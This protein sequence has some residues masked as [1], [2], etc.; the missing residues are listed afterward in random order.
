MSCDRPAASVRILPTAAGLLLLNTSSNCLW[1]CNDSARQVWQLIEQGRSGDDLAV[2]FA[3]QHGIPADAARRDVDAIVTQ[4][5]SE[6]FISTNGR[7]RKPIGGRSESGD[8][9]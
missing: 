7:S 9:I 2:D 6:G 8:R 1:A 3:R 5:R 4:W